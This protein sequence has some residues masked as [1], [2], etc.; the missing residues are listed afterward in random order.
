MDPLSV[1]ASLVAIFQLAATVN[2]YLKGVKGG[3]EEQIRL[4]EEIRSTICLFEIL[5]DRVEDAESS[6][7]YLVSIRSLNI[8]GG[9]L[10]QLRGALDQ[11][12]VKLAPAGRLKVLTQAFTWPLTTADVNALLATIERQ[13]VL[14]GLAMQDDNM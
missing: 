12:V 14:F 2:Q 1:S 13:K 9:P 6:E 3:S 7:K 8:P 4:R 11:L 10:E 5:N